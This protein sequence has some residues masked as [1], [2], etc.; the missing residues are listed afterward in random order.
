MMRKISLEDLAKIAS[1]SK[2]CIDRIYL[3]WSAGT[4]NNPSEDYHVNICADGSLLTDANSLNERKEHT[5]Q[6]NSNTVGVSILCCAGASCTLD[7]V[8]TWGD[9]PPTQAQIE[10]MGKVVAVL[11]NNLG[12]AI[13]NKNVMTHAEIAE[14]DGYAL[15]QDSDC[16]WDLLKLRDYDDTYRSGGDVIRGKALWYEHK[17]VD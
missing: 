12:L 17:G 15:G 4:Y 10:M 7:G 1:R 16:R 11:C 6:R 8:V 3:H 9:Y 2:W 14:V 13:N 5:W